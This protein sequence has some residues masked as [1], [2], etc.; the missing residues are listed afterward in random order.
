MSNAE[1][2]FLSSIAPAAERLETELPDAKPVYTP[3]EAR[4]EAERCLFCHDAPCVKACPTEI[5]IPLFIKKIASG[6]VRG[7]ARTILD[8]NI[9]GYSCA[10]VCPVE[11]LCVGDC[12]YNEWHRAPIQIGKLQRYATETLLDKEAQ[13]GAP[14]LTPKPKTEASKRVALV[15]GGP[16][17]LA[18]A[19]YL[20]LE[21]HHAVIFEKNKL[22]GGLNTTGV[23]PYKLHAEDAL[24]E[25]EFVQKLGV[26]IRT[27]VE[28][29]SGV[30]VG[31]L[32]S[33]YDAVFLGLGLGA[34]SK[35]GIP[36]EEGRA[37]HGATAYI[38][39]IKNETGIKS[40]R[41][42]RAVV[43]GGGNT[44][45]DAAREI[46]MLGAA[47]VTM[48]YR[49]PAT[50]MSGY[51]HEMAAARL[52]GVS[53]VDSALPVAVLRDNE[54]MV[55]GLR[56]A[57]TSD[58]A[59]VPGTERDL[60]CDLVVV[61]IGQSKLRTLAAEIEGVA[62]D[63]RGCVVV[64]KK[65]RRTNNPR[66]YAGGDCINGGKEVVNAVA[67]GRDAARAMMRAWAEGSFLTAGE[68]A[69]VE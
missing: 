11:V 42:R 20:A 1:H 13:G 43:V 33:E 5:D 62:L 61:A 69:G 41:G 24:R 6:N 47:E 51:T 19:A 55:T 14:L 52:A 67:D 27:G 54:G 28:V 56:V 31:S 39:R 46:A 15:G 59:V 58:G 21:G 7:S 63:G 12:V 26:E 48:L 37:V 18:C 49:R 29:G 10:R 8:S 23:A 32:L 25:V 3:S 66:V 44:A 53:L 4:A 35:L 60:P 17:S 45:I 65:T 34:D 50:S 36:G 40:P 22:P 38:E 30:T 64:D 68:T 57:S 16:A 9:L 2:P